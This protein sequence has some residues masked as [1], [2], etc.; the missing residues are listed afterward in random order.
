MEATKRYMTLPYKNVHGQLYRKKYAL[1]AL[2]F[3][4]FKPFFSYV[5]NRFPLF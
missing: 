5:W 4:L 3:L 2:I 1:L